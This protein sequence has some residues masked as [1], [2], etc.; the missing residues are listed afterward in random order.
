MGE[1]PDA[2]FAT[3]VVSGGRFA[4]ADVAIGDDEVKAGDRIRAHWAAANFDETMFGGPTEVDLA[5]TPNRHI[6][7]A[8]GFHRCLGSHLARMEMRVALETL[9]ARIPDYR[10]DPDESAGLN[11]TGIRNVDALPLVLTARS[12]E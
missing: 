7:F 2:S 1:L 9:H 12:E 11:N 4:T 6:A 8:S 5:R 3:P 10:L